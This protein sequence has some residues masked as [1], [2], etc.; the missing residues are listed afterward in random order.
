MKD[1]T[2]S[3]SSTA[4]SA[5]A[6][7]FVDA[8]NTNESTGSLVTQVCDVA[9]K[10]LKGEAMTDDDR[11]SIV[12]NIASAKGWKRNVLK[13]RSSEVNVVL[14]AY[15]ALPEAI[16]LLTKR[17]DGRAQWHDS[18][19]LARRINA[20]DSTQKAVAFAMRQKQ[21]GQ[22]NPMGRLAGALKSAWEAVPR[23]RADIV[24]AAQLLG[25]T[26]KGITE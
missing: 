7:S 6:S 25:V 21:P 24:K 2:S 11:A 3:L 22:G 17:N 19:K 1:K 5:I 23:K 18:M 16:E 4:I 15:H 8:L 10:Y 9:R 26:L 14:K 13:Q 20:G 12:T